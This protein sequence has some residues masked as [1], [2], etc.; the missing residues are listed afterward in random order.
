[1]G[2]KPTGPVMSHI[3]SYKLSRCAIPTLLRLSLTFRHFIFA[4]LLFFLPQVPSLQKVACIF[5]PTVLRP[6]SI[7]SRLSPAGCELMSP[8]ESWHVSVGTPVTC[9]Y[10]VL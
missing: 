6:V 9:L 3:T 4:V 2:K 7:L 10:F 8:R 5:L 1:M